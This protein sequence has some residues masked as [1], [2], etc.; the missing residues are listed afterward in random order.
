MTCISKV[1]GKKETKKTYLRL[2]MKTCLKPPVVVV[3][4]SGGGHQKVSDLYLKKQLAL[5]K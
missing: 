4:H 5:L 1:K 2:E 3:V